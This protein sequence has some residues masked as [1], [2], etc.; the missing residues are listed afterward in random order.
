M[1]CLLSC[2]AVAANRIGDIEFFGYKGLDLARV[3]AALPIH[4]GDAYSPDAKIQVREA[5]TR[6]LGKAPTD[7]T[8]IC[9]DE[10]HNEVVFVGLP[11]ASNKQVTYNPQPQGGQRLSPDIEALYKKL[12]ATIEAAVRRDAKSA[13]EDVSNGYSLINDP[14]ARALE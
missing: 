13:Q 11:G 8:G 9:C 7:V 14:T 6:V 4:Q 10:Q 12:D 3:R 2:P 1:L 5:V